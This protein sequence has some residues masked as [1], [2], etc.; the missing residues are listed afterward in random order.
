MTK[1]I[2]IYYLCLFCLL[3]LQAFSTVFSNNQQ[4]SRRLAVSQLEARKDSLS[5]EIRDLHNQ[6]AINQSLLAQTANFSDSDFHDI[7]H[8][9]VIDS[10]HPSLL[11]SL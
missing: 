3:L 2:G 10:S 5:K 9:L 1:V 4:L 6:T 7:T 11:G 8:Q